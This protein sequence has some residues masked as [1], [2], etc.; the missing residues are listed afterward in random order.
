MKSYLSSQ[1]QITAR[2]SSVRVN[3]VGLVV[4]KARVRARVR[5]SLIILVVQHQSWLLL[6]H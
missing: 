5:F 4:S 6:Q 1:N 3:M 2:V